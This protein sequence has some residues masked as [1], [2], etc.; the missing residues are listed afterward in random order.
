MSQSDSQKL[1]QILAAIGELKTTVK[2][3]TAVLKEHT[4]AINGLENQVCAL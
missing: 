4:K 3:H 1:D 2:E